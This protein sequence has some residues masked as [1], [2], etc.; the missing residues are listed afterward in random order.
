MT[1]FAN[2][3]IQMADNYGCTLTI[4]DKNIKQTQQNSLWYGGEI[5]TLKKDGYTCHIYAL[6]NVIGSIYKIDA[7][8]NIISELAYVKDKINL[9]NFGDELRNYIRNDDELQKAVQGFKRKNEKHGYKIELSNNNWWE[10]F[11][12]SPDGVYHDLMWNLESDT[13][14]DAL[15]EVLDQLNELKKATEE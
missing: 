9:G 7:K 1:K 8:G 13:I 11:V 14:K 6:G 3:L 10:V 5:L 2:E 12:T 15:T 4:N